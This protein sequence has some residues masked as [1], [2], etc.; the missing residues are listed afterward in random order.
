MAKYHIMCPTSKRSSVRPSSSFSSTSAP[1]SASTLAAIWYAV[2]LPRTCRNLASHWR[3][4]VDSAAE[5]EDRPKQ[6]PPLSPSYISKALIKE[7]L[8]RGKRLHA[9][10]FFEAGADL[11]LS[12]LTC[13]SV[14][15][16]KFRRCAWTCFLASS[17]DHSSLANCSFDVDVHIFMHFL[18]WR[19][20]RATGRE[21]RCP[22]TRIILECRRNTA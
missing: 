10:A 21:S 15:G 14:Q 4:T 8:Q 16:C 20:V 19:S 6:G 3:P 22:M 1:L 9:A 11:G 12:S 17:C 5:S 13:R 18:G 7:C 2:R